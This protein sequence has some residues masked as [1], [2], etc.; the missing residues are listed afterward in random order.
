VFADVGEGGAVR[1]GL[2]GVGPVIFGGSRG[3]TGDGG[4]NGA[5]SGVAAEP[6]AF[7]GGVAGVGY[8]PG[9]PEGVGFVEGSAGGHV[10]GGEAGDCG[11][12]GGV[13]W[14]GGRRVCDRR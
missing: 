7:G 14:A 3:E 4:G 11:C 12:D 9:G 2:D 6:D 13:V 10:L 5:V 1:E 8:G